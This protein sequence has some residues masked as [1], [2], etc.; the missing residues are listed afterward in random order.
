MFYKASYNGD[1]FVASVALPVNLCTVI[2][3]A[4]KAN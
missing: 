2:A 3:A 1:H 4:A